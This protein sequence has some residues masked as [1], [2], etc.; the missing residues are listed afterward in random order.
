MDRGR[1]LAT[2]AAF[3]AGLALAVGANGVVS[4]ASA[5]DLT[6]GAPDP[7]A[8][9]AWVF[10]RPDSTAV[11]R[12]N[13]SEMGQGVVTGL[14]MLVAEELD[15]PFA[16]IAVEVAPAQD[17]YADPGFRDMTTGGSQSMANMYPILRG[18]GA[19]ARAMFV[20]AA[21][22][23]WNVPPSEC[24]TAAGSVVHA[25]SNRTIA[26][27]AVAIAA[28]A[29]P[30]PK[31]VPLKDP[32]KFT[33]IGTSP[34]RT[35][36]DAKV[37]AKARYGLDVVV[38]G[39]VYATVLRPPTFGATLAHVDSAAA[40]KVH[41][42]KK[43]FPV[44]A[45]VAVV[46]TN[47]WAAMQGREK[48]KATWTPGPA[49]HLDSHALFAEGEKLAKTSGVVVPTMS[50]GDVDA[51]TGTVHEAVYRGPY[52]AHA[53]MEPMNATAHVR[54]DRVEVWASTQVQSRV[55]DIAAKI[56][57]VPAASVTVH[58]T[59]L[60]GGFGGRL[61]VDPI[62]DAVEI[63]KTM[64]LPVKVTWRREDDIKH[65]YFRAMSVNVVRAKLDANGKPAAWE[66]RVAS[67]SVFKRW[68]PVAFNKGVDTV[69]VDGATPAGYT[70]AAKRT[71]FADH[72]TG[73][74]VGFMRAPG[75]NWNTFV[76]ESF[77]DELAHAAK[78]D[79]LAYRLALLDPASREYAVLQLA[80]QKA[81]YGK[82]PA[83]RAHGIALCEW[84]GSLGALVAE[85][86]MKGKQVVVH[87]V[88]MAADIGTVVHPDIARA[89]L[90]GAINYGIAMA[91][92]A[93]ITIKNGA[94]EQ[95]N[96]DDYTVLRM[97]DAPKIE[98]HLVAS[99]VKPTGV[100]ELGTPPIA[101]AIANAVFSLTGKRVR[102]LPFAD[103]LA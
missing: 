28:A 5:A 18:A 63:S 26:Y 76:T 66:H 89:Q 15:L 69:S 78:S 92:D 40:L 45:G 96:F 99:T 51:A 32:A 68:L 46:A 64:K 61:E 1:F 41:G 83:G 4:L 100:G 91:M 85:C 95:N 50:K 14:P 39:M 19:T 10:V 37:H 55:R 93:K 42:V 70:F 84:G 47:T 80:A 87:R 30:V 17:R 79:P 71:V 77:L 52:L 82:H 35:D 44:A 49:A 36:I 29:L 16:R 9:N 21:A 25:A 88:V 101:P 43:V 12:I 73:V 58:T 23:Q 7:F 34:K 81:N 3:G 102:T 2:T 22:A 72:E 94:V 27:G 103:A 38:P 97:V 33:L 74:P 57:G 86:S 8:T 75:A 90:E 24:T 56:A 48:L 98:T 20:S 62:A 60:G 13:K 65:D 6:D 53:A 59:F 11:V 31:D 67:A 54:A